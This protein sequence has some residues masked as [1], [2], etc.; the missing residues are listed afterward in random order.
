MREL[1]PQG[2]FVAPAINDGSRLAIGEA[3]GQVEELLGEPLVG[4]SGSWLRG[5]YDEDKREWRGGLYSKAGV[6][7]AQVSRANTLQCR[8]PQNVYPTDPDGRSYISLD[9]ANQV[10]RHCFEAH[11]GPLLRSRD[12]T[13]IDLLGDKALRVVGEKDGGIL[14]WRGSPIAVP[15]CGPTLRAVPTLHPSALARDQRFIPVVVHDLKK[16]LVCPPENYSPHP[17]LEEVKEFNERVFAFDIE[18]DRSTDRVICVGLAAATGRSICVPAV[19]GYLPEL[20]RIF[21]GAGEVVGHN[22]VQFDLPHLRSAGIEIGA[23]VTV[24]DTMLLQHLLQ[25]DLPHDLGF[26]GSIFTNKP[27]WK[28]ESGDDLELYCVAPETRTLTAD[29]RWVPLGDCR[30]GDRLIGFDENLHERSYLGASVITSH[31]VIEQPR[32]EVVTDKGTVVATPNHGWAVR[33][34]NGR[35]N[36]KY[37]WITTEYLRPGDEIVFYT[38]PWDVSTTHEAGWLAGLL[39][40]EGTVS[41]REIGRGKLSFSQRSGVVLDRALAALSSEGIQATIGEYKGGTHRDVN[42]VHLHEPNAARPVLEMLGRLQPSRLV[43]KAR[44]LWDGRSLTGAHSPTTTAKV[45]EI[46]DIGIGPVV[47]VGTSTKTLFTEGLASHNC[48]RDTDVTWQCFLQLRALCKAERLLPIYERISRPLASICLQMHLGGVTTDPK[49]IEVV[50]D[51]LLRESAEAERDLPSV[52]RTRQEAIRRRV[53]A[54][55]GTLGKS[56]KPVKFQLVPAEETVVPWRSPEALGHWL[57]EELGLPEQLHAKSAKRTS[58]KTALA[59][60]EAR[61]AKGAIKKNTRNEPLANAGVLAGYIRAVQKLRKL[62]ELLTTFVKGEMLKVE[63]QYPHFNVHGTSSGRLSSSEPNLQNI[64][65]SARYVYVPSHPTWRFLEVDYSQLENR[66]TAWFANDTERLARLSQPGFSEHKWLASEF[67]GIPY[68]EVVKDN[69]RDA[70]YGKG[71]T[72]GHAK[73]YGFGAKKA[74]Q[75]FDMDLAEVKRLF[76]HWAVLNA[77]TVQWQQRTTEEAKRA[78]VLRNPFGRPRWFYTDS[79]YTESLS[80]LPQSTGADIMHRAAVGLLYDRVGLD[81]D[82][83]NSYITH[84]EPIP[85]E[86]RLVLQ[87][88]DSFLF[89]GPGELMLETARTVRRVME[90]PWPELGG[91]SIPVEMKLGEAGMS[92]GELEPL[93]LEV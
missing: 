56:G 80:F 9:D 57:Y 20:R 14:R 62:D 66:L 28:H 49:R 43:Q 2:T 8:P 91:L 4:P 42:I 10:V 45:L 23:E 26:L 79:Y 1:F 34:F 31:E 18:T 30:V 46:R 53:P 84:A 63:R 33:L 88:H 55:P 5:R 21:R 17:S 35:Q 3:P 74:A 85:A 72:I 71:K 82:Y 69:S 22:C 52:L 77:V 92:W 81:R 15:A 83:V 38:R 41:T 7:D 40:G 19:G 58:D 44:S 47:A 70:P 89:E 78:G 60:L 90:Q 39:D 25:P 12:W 29:L 16:N 37:R 87:V 76:E 6:R 36:S 61:L 27:A 86:C 67:F 13:R 11:L 73:N 50:R 32:R 54:A 51:K 75:Q 65:E 68:D 64:P 93:H 59:K 24:W 48:C